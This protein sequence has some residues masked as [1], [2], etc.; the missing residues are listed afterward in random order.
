MQQRILTQGFG[1]QIPIADNGTPQ[2]REQ[3]RRVELRL[4]PLRA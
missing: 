3:N 4:V 1:E 2:G